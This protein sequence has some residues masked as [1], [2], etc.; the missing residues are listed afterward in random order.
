MQAVDQEKELLWSFCGQQTWPG[1]PGQGPS[2]SGCCLAIPAACDPEP[3]TR[4][5]QLSTQVH[6]SAFCFALGLPQEVWN[7]TEIIV[8]KLSELWCK[9]SLIR[10]TGVPPSTSSSPHVHLPEFWLLHGYGLRT[11]LSFCFPPS[12][13]S[14]FLG[15]GM[16]HT[17]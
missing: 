11:R 14:P 13:P 5:L 3:G 9:A 6:S 10:T 17:L 1:G 16:E 12:T 4:I 15:A 2:E 8:V 7:T